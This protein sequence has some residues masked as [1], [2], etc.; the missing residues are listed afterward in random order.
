MVNASQPRKVK[1]NLPTSNPATITSPRRQIRRTPTTNFLA[2]ERTYRNG[3]LDS[4]NWTLATADLA[5]P[6]VT[7]LTLFPEASVLFLPI[8]TS[9][10]SES[11][12]LS[13]S[14][15]DPK[16]TK[17]CI[18][19]V[20]ACAMEFLVDWISQENT[21]MDTLDSFL[22]CYRLLMTPEQLLTRIIIKWEAVGR[23]Q[24]HKNYVREMQGR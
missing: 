11:A 13:E 23:L 8:E 1:E 5:G 4:P 9:S 6:L 21:Y 2:L 18:P 20:K 22:L 3:S 15:N 14:L 19:R 10:D 16:A 17:A 12:L 24:G 7:P